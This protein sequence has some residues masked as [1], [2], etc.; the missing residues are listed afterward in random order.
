VTCA[1]P[2]PFEKLVDLWT[3]ELGDAESVED[4]LFACDHCAA[5]SAQ[6]DRL[7]GSLLHLVPPVLTRGLRDRLE[8]RGL[9][10]LDMAFDAG[11]RGEAFFAA[12]LDLMVFA[13]RAELANAQRVD[14]DVLDGTGHVQFAFTA[15]PFDPVRGEVLVAC[16]QHFRDYPG[17]GDPEFRIYA[18]QAGTRRQVG[19]YVIKHVWPPL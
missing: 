17:E 18:V 9:K 16:Q 19:S 12:D 7:I 11:A 8:E 14:L 1:D 5:Q 13:L 10:I 6:L 3:G 2:I 4:H 15:V